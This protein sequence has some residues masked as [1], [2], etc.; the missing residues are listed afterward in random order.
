MTTRFALLVLLIAACGDDHADDPR[1]KDLESHSAD[2]RCRAAL[3]L[4]NTTKEYEPGL[5]L[6][7]EHARSA[8]PQK[9]RAAARYLPLAK[10][11]PADRIAELARLKNRRAALG[12]LGAIGPQAKAHVDVVRQNLESPTLSVQATAAWALWRIEGDAGQATR[13]LL[14]VLRKTPA[15]GLKQSIADQILDI[16]KQ[17]PAP[18][19]AALKD[20]EHGEA[21]RQLLAFI[22]EDDPGFAAAQAAL[23]G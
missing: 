22:R 7:L 21:A 17:Q 10:D 19:I 5:R 1:L 8:D 16:A 3:E 20:K 13:R 18:L 11:I 12:A 15:A 14:A 2:T 4:W 23:N 6:L 9:K